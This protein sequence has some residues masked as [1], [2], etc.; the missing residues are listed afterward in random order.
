MKTK[1]YY[2]F[3][4]ITTFYGMH[5]SPTV[6]LFDNETDLKKFITYRWYR[7]EM[8]LIIPS[9]M[10]SPISFTKLLNYRFHTNGYES[11]SFAVAME[12]VDSE[13]YVT[14]TQHILD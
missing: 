4:S 2:S 1:N 11:F 7:Q 12:D 13:Q 9:G 3:S 6:I 14:I 8:G 10:S 5:S